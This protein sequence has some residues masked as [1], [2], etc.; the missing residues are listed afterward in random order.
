MPRYQR[1]RVGVKAVIF[2]RDR[3][4]MLRRWD[5]LDLHPGVWDL[6]GGGVEFGDSLEGSL[7]R[8]VNEETGFPVR[9]G[10][11]IHAWIARGTPRPG[12]S[13]FSVIICYSCRVH[14]SQPPRLDPSEHDEFAWVGPRALSTYDCPPDQLVAIQKAFRVR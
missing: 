10:R 4:L 1:A 7:I 12:R 14:S 2:R 5:D 3:V 6:P 9:V 13:F 11:P 8:E